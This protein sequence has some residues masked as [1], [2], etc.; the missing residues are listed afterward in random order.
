MKMKRVASIILNRNL[1]KVCDS[2]YEN[3]YK[4]NNAI[5]DIYVVEA[6]SDLGNLSKYVTWH[7]DWNSAK[8]NGLRFNRGMNYGLTKLIEEGR[9]DNYDY[10]F[11]ITNDTVFSDEPVIEKL[12][13]I[14]D[15]HHKLGILSPCSSDWGELKLLNKNKTLYFWFIHNTAYMLRKNFIKSIYN[16][17]GDRILN[18]L[19]DGNNFRGYCSE[20]ELIAKGYSNDWAS[21]ITSEVLCSE[22]ESYLINSPEIIRTEPYEEN[23]KLYVEEGIK[24]MRRKY[25]FNSKWSM[26]Q[27]VKCFYDRFFE[28]N[29]EFQQFQL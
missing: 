12:C 7:A 5:N 9:F 4:N 20:L 28:F 13:K 27:Y 18:L 17:D 6:G 10:F 25:G 29:P 21:G 15:Y 19:F 2:L 23:L 24:W 11:L 16:L 26:Q 1:P 8:T 22:N 14:M 3:L